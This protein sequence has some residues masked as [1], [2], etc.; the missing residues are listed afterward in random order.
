MQDISDNEIFRQL[1]DVIPHTGPAA[2]RE[3]SCPVCLMDFEDDEALLKHEKC[4]MSWHTDCLLTWLATN[5]SC[6]W[7]RAD[8]I[9]PIARFYTSLVLSS[10]SDSNRITEPRPRATNF[11]TDSETEYDNVSSVVEFRNFVHHLLR[12]RRHIYRQ[13]DHIDSFVWP[14]WPEGQ[15]HVYSF[16]QNR[17][18]LAYRN[19]QSRPRSS[20]DIPLLASADTSFQEL[21]TRLAETEGNRRHLQAL[22]SMLANIFSNPTDGSRIE[23]HA[24]DEEGIFDP[25]FYDQLLRH[26]FDFV[27]E[28]SFLRD[29]HHKLRCILD[30]PQNA[31]PTNLDHRSTPS[32]NGLSQQGVAHTDGSHL[33]PD[34]QPSQE[35]LIP[36]DESERRLF[37]SSE[38]DS[39]ALLRHVEPFRLARTNTA[40]FNDQWNQYWDQ[41]S[42]GTGNHHIDD[43]AN[44]IVR[45]MNQYEDD[46]ARGP[47]MRY[48]INEIESMRLSM[49]LLGRWQG[50]RRHIEGME[51]AIAEGNQLCML[52]VANASSWRPSSVF[53]SNCRW[54]RQRL[55]HARA[56]DPQGHL[57]PE[58]PP[59]PL[60][61]YSR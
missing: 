17:S 41:Y 12:T 54:Y 9:K 2:A 21:L 38:L 22:Y 56:Q 14:E 48:N 49:A 39:T 47:S 55:E 23:R 3:P 33:R 46:L 20:E 5:G 16:R 8:L 57:W 29:L 28:A 35:L 26:C 52:I 15:V 45:Q 6:P 60:D 43:Y 30:S 44:N 11:F 7:C 10:T 31:D 13:V 59:N 50:Y 40:S 51:R 27:A 18:G 34:D 32:D 36:L 1:Q 25:A 42:V 24:A 37:L 4:G 19:V 58:L 53:V 61:F